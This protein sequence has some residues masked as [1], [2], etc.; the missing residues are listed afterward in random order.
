MSEDSGGS[1]APTVDCSG[2]YSFHFSHAYLASKYVLAGE[3][4]YIQFSGR[5][6]G[7]AP[8]GNHS[9][10]NALQVLVLP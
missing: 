6:P 3:T 1:S 10:S 9:L 4:L 2:A 5:D 8:P 7:F